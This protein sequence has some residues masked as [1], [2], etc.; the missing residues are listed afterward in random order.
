MTHDVFRPPNT[1]VS[2][3]SYLKLTTLSPCS[4]LCTCGYA[5]KF[6]VRAKV[7]VMEVYE[8]FGFTLKKNVLERTKNKN[9]VNYSVV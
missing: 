7:Y 9:H 1:C 4:C 5:M 2:K 8:K 6:M 3:H